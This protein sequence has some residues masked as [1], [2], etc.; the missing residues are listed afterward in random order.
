V[1]LSGYPREWIVL[2]LVALG[3]LP[4]VSVL[5]AQD[6][7]RL[8]LTQSIA[9]RGAVD[10]DPYWKLTIDRAFAHGHW[11]SDKAPGMAVLSLPVYGA[12]EAVRRD[13]DL[14]N[15]RAFGRWGRCDVH[16]R[17]SIARSAR[18]S[19]RSRLGLAGR[20][21]RRINLTTRNTLSATALV[22]RQPWHQP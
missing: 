11:Y 19:G 8:A 16:R 15:H 17:G 18:R 20:R 13:F 10:I 5:T 7:S 21:G 3:T 12:I 6:T 9:R 2:A 22:P 4:L 14:E 1:R